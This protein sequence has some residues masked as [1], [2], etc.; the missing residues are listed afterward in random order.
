MA[1]GLWLTA[2]SYRATN[3]YHNELYCTSIQT[4]MQC[5]AMHE[6]LEPDRGSDSADRLVKWLGICEGTIAGPEICGTI[7]AA[8]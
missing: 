1:H 5:N 2:E 8:K 7:A 3:E 4:T 6:G